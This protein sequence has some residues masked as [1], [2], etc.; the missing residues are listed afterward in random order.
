RKSAVAKMLKKL[1]KLVNIPC[2]LDADALY[3]LSENP[4]MVLP[5]NSILTPHR[6]EM[7]RLLGKKSFSDDLLFLEKCRAYSEEKNV[8]LVL[9][10][11]PTWIFHPKTPPFAMAVGD[12][13]MATAGC[14]DILTGVLAAMLAQGLDPLPAALLGTA[15]HGFAGKLAASDL[16]SYC[17]TASDLLEYLPDAFFYSLSSAPA[18]G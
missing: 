6:Q 10:G 13:G 3:F 7:L 2:V 5:K 11:A 9:K 12:P 4:Q 18:I 1:L 15:L 17:M 8:T 16:T 14:G